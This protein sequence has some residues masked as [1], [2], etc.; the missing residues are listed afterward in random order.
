M[1]CGDCCIND[2][3][4]CNSCEPCKDANGNLGHWV[5]SRDAQG[6]SIRK[7]VPE[8]SIKT[9][10]SAGTI[11]DLRAQVEDLEER[12]Q[13]LEAEAANLNN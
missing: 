3:A 9:S 2:C 8:Q 11:A 1:V 5:W 13:A 6:R 10:S 12:V 7:C 4:T